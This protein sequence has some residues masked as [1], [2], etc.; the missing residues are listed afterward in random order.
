M[1]IKLGVDGQP[2]LEVLAT[3]A[4]PQLVLVPFPEGSDLIDRF[5]RSSQLGIALAALGVSLAF[6]VGIAIGYVLVV[7]LAID[8]VAGFARSPVRIRR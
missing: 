4:N 2:A 1:P 6:I 3:V 5:R 7:P 8:W